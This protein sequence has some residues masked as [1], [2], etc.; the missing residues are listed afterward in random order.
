M[1]VFNPIFVSV[2]D[3]GEFCREIRSFR[4]R[5]FLHIEHQTLQ[6][7]N[8]FDGRRRNF[9]D[10]IFRND[11][12]L[13]SDGAARIAGH[14]FG[15]HADAVTGSKLHLFAVE[16]RHLAHFRLASRV[17]LFILVMPHFFAE[18]VLF[19]SCRFDTDFRLKNPSLIAVSLLRFFLRVDEKRRNI[20][21]AVRVIAADAQ[22][23][24]NF[25][26][27]AGINDELLFSVFGQADVVE[28]FIDL[29]ALPDRFGLRVFGLKKFSLLPRVY[30]P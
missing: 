5:Q 26:V 22:T 13:Q 24:L 18:N 11:G 30:L 16:H 25:P 23:Q 12:G 14:G 21:I 10:F 17:N 29:L 1:F 20:P 19:L 4:F 7:R 15:M 9:S 8:F 27:V 6:K 2:G 28:L 3:W